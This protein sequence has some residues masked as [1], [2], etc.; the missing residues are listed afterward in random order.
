[1]V[2]VGSPSEALGEPATTNFDFSNPSSSSS[3]AQSDQAVPDPDCVTRVTNE[4]RSAVN[5]WAR[6]QSERVFGAMRIGA[7]QG[8]I[9]G[10]TVG[11]GPELPTGF[12]GGIAGG[13]VVATVF[14]VTQI[15][16]IDPEDYMFRRFWTKEFNAAARIDREC[17]MGRTQRP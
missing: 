1:V 17:R 14:G 8:F 13:V 12:V 9:A 4:V 7:I 3:S 16:I 6:Q 5:T 10:A 2:D 15:L 11:L